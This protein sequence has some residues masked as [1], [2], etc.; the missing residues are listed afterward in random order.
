MEVTAERT[1]VF[2]V[3]DKIRSKFEKARQ[4]NLCTLP[5]TF[6]EKKALVKLDKKREKGDSLTDEEQDFV[7]WYDT[8]IEE[9]AKKINDDEDD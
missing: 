8:V 9:L 3:Y 1:I 5:L 7:K 6:G 2:G 4:A